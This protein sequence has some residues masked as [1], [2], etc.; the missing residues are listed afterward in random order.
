ML[1]SRMLWQNFVT[2]AAAT[3]GASS[4]SPAFPVRR[5]RDPLRSNR[6]RSATGWTVV[7]G[8]NDKIDF[9]RGGVKVATIAPG[10]YATGALLATAVVA[11]LEAADATPVWACA[12]SPSTFKFTLS[13]DLA[14][15]LLWST[16]ANSDT[17]VG[18]DLGFDVAADSAS[19]LTHTGADAVYQSRH[20]LTF[21]FGSIQ[22]VQEVIVFDHNS[23][24][25]GTWTAQAATL[26]ADVLLAPDFSRAL[27]NL[28]NVEEVRA[29]VFAAAETYRYWA[30]VIDDRANADGFVEAGI[31][32]AGYWLT[33][34]LPAP[35]LTRDPVDYSGAAF[36]DQGAQSQ[37]RKQST[38]RWG[39]KFEVLSESQVDELHAAAREL[40]TGGA[41]FF[42]RDPEE[43][44]GAVKY[45]F[46]PGLPRI[47][48][49]A[50]DKWEADVDL[51]ECLG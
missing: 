21:D 10:T 29:A 44:A 50:A 36:A 46:L 20:Y 22:D 8:W 32:Y 31:A 5:F 13:G 42:V 3:L 26:A 19:A 27:D 37:N 7:A 45:V 9:N 12:Y 48:H 43:D 38:S 11:A 2:L 6:W 14:F 4:A 33:L 23:V 30:L 16:G 15:T 18:L 41:F 40:L 25:G 51:Q 17:S 24:S 34:D 49:T 28:E 47:R 39:Y 1:A 35:G